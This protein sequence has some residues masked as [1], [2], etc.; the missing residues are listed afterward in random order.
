MNWRHLFAELYGTYV[1]TFAITVSFGLNFAV[2]PA[3]FIAIVSS[4]MISGAHFNPAVTTCYLLVG[5]FKKEISK[6]MIYQYCAYFVV[7]IIGGILGALAAWALV[8]R[9]FDMHVSDYYSTGQGFFGEFM[10]TVA[11][12][13]TTLMT[14][15]LQNTGIVGPLVIGLVYFFGA[16]VV[17]PI[18]GGAFNPAVGMGAN[19]TDAWNHGGGDRVKYLWLYI[20]APLLGGII[21]AILFF[22][23]VEE[24]REQQGTN[25][26]VEKKWHHDNKV[27]P[28]FN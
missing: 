22:I 18:T 16:T 15:E 3:I 9:T 24:V 8:G 1:L 4:G 2:G 25:K 17:G 5:V 28:G 7:Q 21:S 23:L 26:I 20:L 14:G 6:D 13:M 19:F 12:C 11:L 27:K 10:I